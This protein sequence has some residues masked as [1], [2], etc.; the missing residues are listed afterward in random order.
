MWFDEGDDDLW[1]LSGEHV[2]VG[3]S[4]VRMM[5]G[6]QMF[7]KWLVNIGAL[8]YGCLVIQMTVSHEEGNAI[9]PLLGGEF[10]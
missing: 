3:N 5:M 1:L 9:S 6:I 7:K 10:E 4:G 8:W 2:L